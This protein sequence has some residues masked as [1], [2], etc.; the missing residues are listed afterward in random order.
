[1]CGIAGAFDLE[2]RRTFPAG[3]LAAMCEALAHRG[4]DSRHLHFE[5]GLA[6]GT[7]R[8]SIVDLEGGRQP[9]A[10]EDERVWVST[11]GEL[12]DYPSEIRQLEAKG[13]RFA[14]R[15]DS[16]IWVHRYEDLGE[17]VFKASRGQFAVALWDR[18]A[19]RLLLGRDRLGICPL[20]WARADGWLLWASEAKGILA[21]GLVS[22][23]VDPLGLD[24]VFTFY[25]ASST[26]SCF[27]GI[28]S[29][30]PG[31]YLSI[32]SSQGAAEIRQVRYWDL[33][34]PDAGDELDPDRADDLVDELESLLTASIRRRL[35]GDVPVVSYLSGG[36]DS[37]LVLALATREAGHPL[38]A[39]TVAL[40]GQRRDERDKAS[41]TASFLGAPHSVVAMDLRGMADAYPDL[42]RH[43]EA[44]VIDTTC[45]CTMRL[46]QQVRQGAFK[47]A[48]TGEGADEALLGYGTFAAQK[49][50]RFLGWRIARRLHQRRG[51]GLLIRQAG[52]STR[53]TPFF[54]FDGER[55]GRLGSWEAAGK[56][57]EGVYSP[58]MWESLAGHDPL[59]GLDL[60]SERMTRWHPLNRAAYIDY[61][62]FLAGLLLA[63][64]GDRSSM[65]SS[66]ETRPP[67]LDEDVVAFCARVHPRWR[68]RGLRG[69]WLL[70]KVA[71][72]HLPRA[73]AW[74]R[75]FGF[76]TQLSATFLGPTRPPWVDELLSEESLTRGGLFDPAGVAQTRSRLAA[77][78]LSVLERAALD[79]ALTGVIA[80]QLWLHT[81]VGGGLADLPSWTRPEIG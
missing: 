1:M 8:L 51:G 63:A 34:Y 77:H 54:P 20:F 48:L 53:R 42:I 47:V 73:V 69:K 27:A 6:L 14:T 43:A 66:V 36:V 70:R 78:P 65:S 55:L 76:R 74:R 45:A 5:P 71:A 28:S 31:C 35:R 7:Q 33:D 50:Q 64:K 11:N 75:K 56:G 19:R 21:S 25:A 15:C 57:R 67:F 40:T 72:R 61:K 32:G 30:P 46:A 10:N 22:P 3:A 23:A 17:G 4:P 81:F 41:A 29:L 18:R 2:G 79:V 62:V 59:S 44:P 37:S 52:G 39:F 49:V 12:F 68:L 26:R 80:S 38:R 60:P 58:S 24:H 13:H 9:L 16:E